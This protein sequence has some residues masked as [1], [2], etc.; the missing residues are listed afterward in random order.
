MWTAPREGMKHFPSGIMA[1]LLDNNGRTAPWAGVHKLETDSPLTEISQ[2]MFGGCILMQPGYRIR[3]PSEITEDGQHIAARPSRPQ[4][5]WSV[6]IAIDHNVEG[7]QAR[8]KNSRPALVGVTQKAFHELAISFL[9]G[10][11]YA[12]P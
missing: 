9:L 12:S 1:D 11:P 3:V 8:S 4:P 7:D 2:E 5:W 6:H 10:F